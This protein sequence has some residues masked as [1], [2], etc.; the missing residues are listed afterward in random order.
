[1]DK[2]TNY[3]KF[4][5]I[6]IDVSFIQENADE[7]NNKISKFYHGGT[8]PEEK[9]QSTSV[10]QSKDTEEKTISGEQNVTE[11]STEQI[12][13]MVHEQVNELATKM[14]QYANETDAKI[15]ALQ[16]EI[17]KLQSTTQND[18]PVQKQET[19]V[20]PEEKKAEPSRDG[21]GE[22]DVSIEKMFDFSGNS[23]GKRK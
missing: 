20:K 1:M 2:E 18:E 12:N 21:Y 11:I 6:G 5:N 10:K 16:A 3:E 15:E 17:A 23:T 9:I 22:N 4:K 13:Q 7:H 14:Q 19:L 8:K